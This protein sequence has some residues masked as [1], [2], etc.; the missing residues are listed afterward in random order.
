VASKGG[1]R[2][3]VT[4]GGSDVGGGG[5]PKK[6]ALMGGRGQHW[7]GAGFVCFRGKR[8]GGGPRGG[9]G[10]GGGTPTGGGGGQTNPFKTGGGGRVGAPAGGGGSARKN[11]S[12]GGGGGAGGGPGKSR[13]Y[14]RAAPRGSKAGFA[15]VLVWGGKNPKGRRFAA[16]KP[17]FVFNNG[18]IGPERII[19]AFA[20]NG[21]GPFGGPSFP[22]F[23]VWRGGGQGGR[24]VGGGGGGGGDYYFSRPAL[25]GRGRNFGKNAGQ[26]CGWF[27]FVFLF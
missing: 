17:F 25:G 11:L 1:L 24:G 2:E 20:H 9:G 12:G 16:K 19:P 8:G 5:A 23:N 22:T 18:K 14:H 13:H 21:P 3:G 7:A 27:L 6:A 4:F 15:G 10:A 26:K